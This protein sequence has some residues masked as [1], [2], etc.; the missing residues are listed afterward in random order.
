MLT[1][2]PPQVRALVCIGCGAETID[3]MAWSCT[4]CGPESR[5]DVAYH[6]A[7]P[8][9]LA[10]FAARPFDQFRYHELLPIPEGARLPPIQVGGSSVSAAP[11]N[12]PSST[13]ARN[14]PP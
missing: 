11:R 12:C 6:S 14:W 5:M 3:P 1:R 13:R 8:G 9:V 2:L 4:A 10:R 7:P